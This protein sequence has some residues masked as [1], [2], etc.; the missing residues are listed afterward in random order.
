MTA[1]HN[2]VQNRLAILYEIAMAIGNTLD[3]NQAVLDAARALLRKLNATQLFLF[4][5]KDANEALTEPFLSLPRQ[6]I[7]ASYH[8]LCQAVIQ[9]QLAL[10]HQ[11]ASGILDT[12][13]FSNG[14]IGYFFHLKGVGV[15]FLITS[16]PLGCMM[17]S[18]LSP[19][20]D[21]LSTVIQSC[22]SNR[23]LIE[24]ERELEA[25][26]LDLRQA[27]AARDG[28]LANMSHEIRT[29]LHG[30][31]G[32]VDQLA[33]TSLD[34]QQRHYINM[35]KQ[36]SDMLLGIIN[37]ILDFSKINAGRLVLEQHEF[38][39]KTAL[40]PIVE[41]FQLRTDPLDIEFVYDY[42]VSPDLVCLSDPLRIK[43]V[44]TNLLS[45]AVK[46]THEGQVVFRVTTVSETSD[47]VVLRF[48]IKDSGIGMSE[49]HLVRIGEPFL[50][51]DE[52]ITRVYGGTG[53]GLVICMRLLTLFN[54]RLDIESKLYQG[55]CFE[56]ELTLEKVSQSNPA[57]ITRS[58]TPHFPS[59]SVLVVEDNEVNQMLM[60]VILQKLAID[61]VLAKNGLEAFQQVTSQRFDLILMD[62]NMP[63]MDGYEAMK[64]IRAY[65]AENH[66]APVPIIAL[67]ANVLQGDKARYLAS[68]ADAILAKPLQLDALYQQ[69]NRLFKT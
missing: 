5:Y 19:V 11:P 32:F 66:L 18:A 52:S 67:T 60:K 33:Q 41:M 16:H 35:A 21:K 2:E 61:P 26:L 29:P 37:D 44:I 57:V 48:S 49:A 38:A 4:Y 9:Q 59:K 34:Q 42:Q 13:H 62:I 56:F 53:L 20:C 30:I 27:Q 6:L 40:E 68:G 69:L 63:V 50:Q 45:N 15:I 12:K 22:W 10:E 39:L 14:Q 31:Y 3:E 7:D 17:L 25:T 1:S 47:Q 43:Q 46:F 24:K 23:Q 58:E 28:F 51:G 8:S 64:K 36:S 54:S 55:S 65:E